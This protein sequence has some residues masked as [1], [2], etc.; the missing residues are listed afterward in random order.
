MSEAIGL[1]EMTNHNE[2]QVAHFR[3]ICIPKFGAHEAFGKPE[4]KEQV[5]ERCRVTYQM[6]VEKRGEVSSLT[7]GSNLA[8]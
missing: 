5:L 4:T 2:T 7:Q 6:S 3:A 1:V 8:F